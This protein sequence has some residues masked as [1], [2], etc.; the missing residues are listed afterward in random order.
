MA[1]STGSCPHLWRY[2]PASGRACAAQ[3]IGPAIRQSQH[4]S[5]QARHAAAFTGSTLPSR[6]L[7]CT[8]SRR[9]CGQSL[10]SS[11][12]ALMQAAPRARPRARRR[13]Q[14][15]VCR[16]QAMS[17]QQAC[18][19]LGVDNTCSREEVRAA[20][21]VRIKE[22][23]SGFTCRTASHRTRSSYRPALTARHIR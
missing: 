4:C 16:A 1:Q 9:V 12:A 21:L 19:I 11:R 10:S 17:S 20:Y 3:I 23:N 15:Q 5:G 2:N 7:A 18:R 14:R 13:H 22:V 8:G 6:P